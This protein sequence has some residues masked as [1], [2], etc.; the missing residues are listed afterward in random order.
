MP[1]DSSCSKAAIRLM[2]ETGFG[3]KLTKDPSTKVC[4]FVQT[5]LTGET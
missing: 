1:T 3:T 2:V 5:F 4:R